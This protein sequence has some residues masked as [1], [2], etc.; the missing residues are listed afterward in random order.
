MR[1]KPFASVEE[2]AVRDVAAL[3]K[4][5]ATGPSWPVHRSM[6]LEAAERNKSKQAG[7][8]WPMR[9]AVLR[10]LVQDVELWALFR[11][12]LKLGCPGFGALPLT[13]L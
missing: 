1:I 6:D 8:F 4:K 2:L 10:Q 5:A 13:S 12:F 7:T 9:T 11:A 3:G